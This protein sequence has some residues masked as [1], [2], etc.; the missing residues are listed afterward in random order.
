MT[1]NWL[2]DTAEAAALIAEERD[3]RKRE[4]AT[5]IMGAIEQFAKEFP[6][7]LESPLDSC[8]VARVVLKHLPEMA[9]WLSGQ[10][11]DNWYDGDL[12]DPFPADPITDPAQD[13]SRGGIRIRQAY[14]FVSSKD[15]GLRLALGTFLNV[16]ICDQGESNTPGTRSKAPV[17]LLFLVMA[18]D[19]ALRP[20]RAE[21]LILDNWGDP[22]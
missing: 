7:L 1:K 17:D 20:G 21:R 3:P 14:N 22:A 15:G 12:A 16:A 11:L 13:R 8:F 4:A 9:A 18:L 6:S 19:Y 5:N 2:F 10:E